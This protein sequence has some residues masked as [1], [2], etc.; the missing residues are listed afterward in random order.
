M[1]EN[2]VKWNIFKDCVY[3][4]DNDCYYYLELKAHAGKMWFRFGLRSEIRE[5]SWESLGDMIPYGDVFFIRLKKV[6]A[7]RGT[8]ADVLE[9]LIPP[10]VSE[11]CTW[12][13]EL[14]RPN[15]R[16]LLIAAVVGR[17]L[18]VWQ[19]PKL[20]DVFRAVYWGQE[21]RE[22]LCHALSVS[23]A[24]FDG[25]HKAACVVVDTLYRIFLDEMEEASDEAKIDWIRKWSGLA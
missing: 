6:L 8:P 22:Q 18:K 1:S 16:Q 17:A 10:C 13:R 7:D 20:T 5:S 9:D 4:Y 14:L 11:M 23:D 19:V 3:D 15:M 24:E 2:Y 21:E 12:M 25:A